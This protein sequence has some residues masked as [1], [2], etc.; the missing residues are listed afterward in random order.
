M[1]PQEFNDKVATK[2]TVTIPLTITAYTGSA[3]TMGALRE[4]LKKLEESLA[5]VDPSDISGWYRWADVWVENISCGD[6]KSPTVLKVARLEV[7]VTEE[8]AEA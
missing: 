2:L 5:P 1:T 4:V 7:P 8:V 6:I 3:T